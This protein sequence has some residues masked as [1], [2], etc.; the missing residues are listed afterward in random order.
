MASPWCIPTPILPRPGRTAT[1]ADAFEDCQEVA[2]RGYVV[3]AY[4]RDP[5]LACPC[6]ARQGTGEAFADVPAGQRAEERLP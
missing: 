4:A 3:D 6:D 2:R 1:P 5:G